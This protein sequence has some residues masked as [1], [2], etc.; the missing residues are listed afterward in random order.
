MTDTESA[1]GDDQIARQL[2]NIHQTLELIALLLAVL[3]LSAGSIGAI[4]GG[5]AILL[6]VGNAVFRAFD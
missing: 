3:L 6:L 2:S 4:A 1:V 5:C